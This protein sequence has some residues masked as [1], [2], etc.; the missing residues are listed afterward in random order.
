MKK[1]RS[2]YLSVVIY[3]P[4][5]AEQDDEK[6]RGKKEM[7][8]RSDKDPFS[9]SY[10][11]RTDGLGTAREEKDKGTIAGKEHVIPPSFFDGLQP[12]APL[13]EK[14]GKKGK[15]KRKKEKGDK[16]QRNGFSTLSLT[17]TDFLYE[18]FLVTEEDK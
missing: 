1:K 8:E 11:A 2:A 15:K 16:S 10:C 4:H 7:S 17:L 9:V 13:V 18:T 12:L 3:S 6:R 14:G 5:R